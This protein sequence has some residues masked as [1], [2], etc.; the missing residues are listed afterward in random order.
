MVASQKPRV[1]ILN[2]MESSISS[3]WEDVE[4]LLLRRKKI[5]DTN[6]N[7]HEKFETCQ[8]KIS[9]LELA[10]RDTMIP[11]EV[12][13]VEDFLQKFKMMR[14]EVLAS[15]LATL[16]DGKELL[17][18]L[19]EIASEGSLDSRPEYVVQDAIRSIKQVEIWLEQLHDRRNGL[20]TAWQSRKDQ[21]EQCLKLAILSKELNELEGTLNKRQND[22]TIAFTLGESEKFVDHLLRDYVRLKDDAISLRDRAIKITKTVE[23]LVKQGSFDGDEACAKSYSILARCTE[24]LDES[25]RREGLLLQAKD[26]FHRAESALLQIESFEVE[27]AT[28]KNANSPTNPIKVY[29]GILSQLEQTVQQPIQL[30][31]CLMDDVGRTRPEVMGVK[32]VIDEMEKR[33]IYLEEI[34][35][36]NSEQAIDVSEKIN[37]FFSHHNQILSWLVSI[38]EAFIKTNS[39]MGTTL[40]SARSFLGAHHKIL[41]DLEVSLSFMP[42]VC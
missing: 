32:R 17:S 39:S 31:Y 16:R 13:P 5:A 42:T 6:S 1:E 30:G 11:M 28:L 23:S 21:L 40:V 3:I 20:E 14:T 36:A 9:A 18:L 26:F 27:I 41:S 2:A 33:K 34:C 7:F 38:A 24:F 10:C 8:S 25:D 22:M 29:S 19:R 35:T 37:V 15:V 12:E 4:S